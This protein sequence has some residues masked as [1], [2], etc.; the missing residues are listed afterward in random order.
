MLEQF[1]QDKSFSN[2][3]EKNESYDYSNENNTL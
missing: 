3:N 1:S 2:D